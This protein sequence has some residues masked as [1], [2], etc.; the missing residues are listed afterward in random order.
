M[1]LPM[2]L[3]LRERR[4]F[5]DVSAAVSTLICISSLHGEGARSHLGVDDSTS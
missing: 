5:R 4:G 2:P 3:D 1:I